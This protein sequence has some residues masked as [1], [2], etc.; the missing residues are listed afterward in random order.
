MTH[1]QEQLDQHYA[2]RVELDRELR[3]LAVAWRN[4]ERAH[5]KL[6]VSRARA[7]LQLDAGAREQQQLGSLAARGRLGLAAGFTRPIGGY[8]DPQQQ[9]Q[10]QQREEEAELSRL[11]KQL[12]MA[13]RVRHALDRL[14]ARVKEVFREA[15]AQI[16]SAARRPESRKRPPISMYE[17]IKICCIINFI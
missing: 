5:P 8:R 2:R 11:D 17:Y 10:R 16:T 3:A 1:L 13:T 14:E 15:S 9:E 6:S 12:E 4:F 7:A